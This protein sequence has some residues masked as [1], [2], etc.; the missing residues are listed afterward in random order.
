MSHT[1]IRLG[2]VAIYAGLKARL[3][4]AELILTF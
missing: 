3:H 2:T 4:A 1:L